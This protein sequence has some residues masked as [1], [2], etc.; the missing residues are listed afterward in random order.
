MEVERDRLKLRDDPKVISPPAL[1]PAWQCG[2]SVLVRGFIADA[3]LD[4]EVD[5]VVVVSGFP[6]G[7]PLP[8][9]ALV[10]LANPLAAGQK[11]RARQKF[12]GATSA[13][14]PVVTVRDHTVDFPAGPPRPQINPAP[15]YQCGTRTGVGNL[16]VGCD[17]WI[18]ADA[19]EVGRVSGA[20]NQQ[21]VNVAPPYGLGQ[22]VVAFAS[23]CKDPSPPSA[24]HIAQA[25]PLPMP[26]PGFLPIYA[27]GQQLTITNVVNGA[28]LTLSRNGIL[29]FSF[30]MGLS[31]SGR[32]EPAVLRGRGVVG[33]TAAMSGRSA[34]RRRHGDGAALLRPAGARRRAGAGGRH[35]RHAQL[36][37]L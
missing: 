22:S 12:G 17:V 37:R 28:R 18:T 9:G 35:Q 31:A 32:P 23:L 25:Q 5:G 7:F 10:P 20:A 6:G 1:D 8:N 30:S 4:I 14:S 27:G 16:L 26:V 33:H 24:T 19:I 2:K 29:Q 21:G 3:K 34:E 13:W 15:V 36:V 11:I